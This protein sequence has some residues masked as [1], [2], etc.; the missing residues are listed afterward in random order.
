M[1]VKLFF[2]LIALNAGYFIQ[3]MKIK[4]Y[5]NNIKNVIYVIYKI[6]NNEWS[7]GIKDAEKN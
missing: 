7:Q 5:K 1:I 2:G 4:E 3:E 6:L